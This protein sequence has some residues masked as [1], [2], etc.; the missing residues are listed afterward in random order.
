MTPSLHT[1]CVPPVSSLTCIRP[2]VQNRVAFVQ[3]DLL[4][5]H[6]VE[7]TFFIA[8]LVM[9]TR[10]VDGMNQPSTDRGAGCRLGGP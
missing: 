6:C 8:R 3:K 7:W 2:Y 4:E 10:V 1:R 5:A 9:G